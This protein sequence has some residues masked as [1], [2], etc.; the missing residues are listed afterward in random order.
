MGRRIS[1]TPDERE[2]IVRLYRSGKSLDRVAAAVGR[3]I[4]AV[5]NVVK[6]RGMHV[7]HIAIA[8]MPTPE[9][10]EQRKAEIHALRAKQNVVGVR[11]RLV[12]IPDLTVTKWHN[13]KP[14]Y[15]LE[16]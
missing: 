15:E 11:P 1:L 8:P 9:E 16:R 13:G 4:T 3:S 5:R 12:E 7:R 2:R 10:V 14:M 6:K